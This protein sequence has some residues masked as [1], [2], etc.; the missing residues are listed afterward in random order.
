MLAAPRSYYQICLDTMQDKSLF[1]SNKC[2]ISSSFSISTYG[3]ED[4]W[5]AKAS[6]IPWPLWI[7]RARIQWESMMYLINQ[8]IFPGLMTCCYRWL[9]RRPFNMVWL[10][11]APRG[12]CY[13]P[14][15]DCGLTFGHKEKGKI[16]WCGSI[17]YDLIL[18]PA[19]FPL[20]SG[21]SFIYLWVGD[22]WWFVCA[23]H[24]HTVSLFF[25][26]ID[27]RRRTI[28]EYHRVELTKT[29]ITNSTAVEMMPLPSK[30]TSVEQLLAQSECYLRDS[31][32]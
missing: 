18:P 14:L 13:R 9:G 7:I 10:I 27:V 2:C 4:A 1:D 32:S 11:S 29:K 8:S 30:K 12:N 20:S 26:N 15:P 21:A 17:L 6:L 31:L 28:Y 5:P 19:V 22:L 23:S 25:H 16:K 24:S 3:S